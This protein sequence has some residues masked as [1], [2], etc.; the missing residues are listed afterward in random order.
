MKTVRLGIAGLG[1][2][3]QGVLQIIRD[4]QSLIAGRT[5]VTLEVKRVASRTPKPEIDL[6][7]GE[8]VTD[9]SQLLADDVDVV[10]ELIGGEDQARSLIEAALAAGKGVVT[11]NKAVIA[12]HGYELL[13]GKGAVPLK[14]EA[15]VAGAIPIIQAIERGL[16]ANRLSHLV[17]IINGTCNYILTAM[18]EEGE[19][20]AD[21]LNTAQA[22]GYAEADPTFDVEGID[23]GHKLAILTGLA[24]DVAVDFSAL[25]VEGISAITVAD[26]E[27]AKQLGY[28]I[29]HVGIAKQHA[30]D[31]AIEARVHPALVP[32]DALFANVNGVTNA[33][34]INADAAGQ[35]LFSGPGAGGAA[36]ASAVVADILALSRFEPDADVLPPEQVAFMPIDQVRCANYLRIPVRDEPGVFARIA[37]ALSEHNISIEAA[38]QKEPRQRAETV[39]IVILTG[40][41]SE[42]EIEHAVSQV[43]ALPQNVDR[44]A[45]IRV[46]N[47]D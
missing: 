7:G 20:F 14:Y 18:Q 30:Q 9:L 39:A 3:A 44:I 43:Q 16:V 23:A 46:E 26:I 15:S 6:V 8:F 34:L 40:D 32:E 10:V 37:S 36:T 2:V 41:C 22:L 1:T 38:I 17:G 31:G 5:G 21:A 29:K 45:R 47:L 42:A 35:T 13:A 4:N 28:R 27:Y 25:H 24:F 11:A 19:S 12:N 33:V